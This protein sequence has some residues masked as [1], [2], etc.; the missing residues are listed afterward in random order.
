MAKSLSVLKKKYD[1]VIEITHYTYLIVA[2]NGKYGMIDRYSGDLIIPMDYDHIQEA[3]RGFLVQKNGYFG[4]LDSD[5]SILI[6]IEY[7]QIIDELWFGL[8]KKDEKY[9]IYQFNYDEN[10]QL[11]FKKTA[12][13]YDTATAFDIQSEATIVSCT[14]KYGIVNRELQEIV[15]LNYDAISHFQWLPN[16]QYVVIANL[17]SQYGMFNLEHQVIIPFEYDELSFT[18]IDDILLTK[19]NGL[20]AL[21]NYAKNKIKLITPF[22]YHQILAFSDERAG[23]CVQRKK[24]KIFTTQ[25]WGFIDPNGVEIITPQFD[26]II[27]P[28]IKGRAYVELNGERFFIDKNGER[29]LENTPIEYTH[30]IQTL[31]DN[32]AQLAH[33]F[34]EANN[35][36][37][38]QA[39][40]HDLTILYWSM[41]Y[42]FNTNDIPKNNQYQEEFKLYNELRQKMRLEHMDNLDDL[43]RND[44]HYPV[45]S[46]NFKIKIKTSLYQGNADICFV[47]LL[48]NDRVYL[49]K[50]QTLFAS[51]IDMIKESQ[52]F[53]LDH[54]TD[55]DIQ[56]FNLLIQYIERACLELEIYT[57]QN[58]GVFIQQ[59]PN[60]EQDNITHFVELLYKNNILHKRD[61]NKLKKGLIELRENPHKIRKKLEKALDYEKD[62]LID[63]DHEY[64][65]QLFLCDVIYHYHDDWKYDSE[66]LSHFIGEYIEQDFVISESDRKQGLTHINQILESQFNYALLNIDSGSDEFYLIMVTCDDKAEI[67]SLAKMLDIPI[68]EHF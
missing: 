47:I 22:K 52:P 59:E 21:L 44:Q 30:Q 40:Q 48:E 14:G 18:T 42:D 49:T 60:N 43:L 9:A 4:I 55:E 58:Q 46:V 68:S 1:D 65:A 5:N 35:E 45:I 32:V 12:L 26:N 10:S 28:F 39:K 13:K 16:N 63:A 50:T 64:L 25:K 62:D 27:Y 31:K 33:Y 53:D 56:H 6:P 15:P 57:E 19:K 38:Y 23:V 54:L 66:A 8:L 11:N 24:L 7:D 41:P 3:K 29:I 20:Y 17:N 2:K 34:L 37:Y 61:M 67:L 51:Y 36:T